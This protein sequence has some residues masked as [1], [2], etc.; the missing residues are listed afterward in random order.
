[1]TDIDIRIQELE[2]TD[3]EQRYGAIKKL[4]E[5]DELPLEAVDALQEAT[6]DPE[7]LISAMAYLALL[8][9]DPQPAT[10]YPTNDLQQDPYTSREKIKGLALSAVIAILIIP[11]INIILDDR[12]NDLWFIAPLAVLLAGYIAYISFEDDGHRRLLAILSSAAIGLLSGIIIFLLLSGL[13]L[14]GVSAYRGY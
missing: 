4:R 9:H 8:Q 12:L 7:P 5:Q 1:M 14:L 6:T 10:P 13:F 2:S 3:L 11:L